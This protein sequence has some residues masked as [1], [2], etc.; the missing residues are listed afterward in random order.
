MLLLWIVASLGWVEE[1][2][3]SGDAYCTIKHARSVWDS[4]AHI[5]VGNVTRTSSF[6]GDIEHIF[7]DVHSNPIVT[8]S[9]Y[10][11][12]TQSGPTTNVKQ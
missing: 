5:T 11:L 2:L 7:G 12:P 9:F 1:P 8:R 4:L 3:Q 10:T 6:N